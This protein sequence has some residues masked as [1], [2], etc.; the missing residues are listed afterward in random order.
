MLGR[1]RVYEYDGTGVGTGVGHRAYAVRRFCGALPP[2]A[3]CLT[4]CLFAAAAVTS[5]FE[6][7]ERKVTIAGGVHVGVVF[8][9]IMLHSSLMRSVTWFKSRAFSSLS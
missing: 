7:D 4:V 9:T 3:Y 1:A 8:A 6:I 2:T 5:G